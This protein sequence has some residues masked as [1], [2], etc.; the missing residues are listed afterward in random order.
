MLMILESQ[1]ED[2]NECELSEEEYSEVDI[3]G[4]LINSLE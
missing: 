1:N 2:H 4:E 3:E